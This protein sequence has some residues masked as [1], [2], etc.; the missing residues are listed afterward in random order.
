[1]KLDEARAL[2]AALDA[3]IAK[4]EAAGTDD[5]ALAAEALQRAEAALDEA[6]AAVDARKATGG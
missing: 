2:R 4:A 5:V 6:Q 1:M 3:A